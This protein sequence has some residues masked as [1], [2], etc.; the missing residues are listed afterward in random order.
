[1]KREL[2]I[3]F[4]FSK[5]LPAKFDKIMAKYD[6]YITESKGTEPLLTRFKYLEKELESQK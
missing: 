4:G 1:M 3:Y 6:H 2:T 5:V